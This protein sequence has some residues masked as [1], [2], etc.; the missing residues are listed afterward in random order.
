MT[1]KGVV[2]D[3]DRACGHA[4]EDYGRISGE[5]DHEEKSHVNKCDFF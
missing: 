1:M 3:F 4:V 2:F 5:S